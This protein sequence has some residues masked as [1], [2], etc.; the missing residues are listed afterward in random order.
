VAVDFRRE[1]GWGGW[2]RRAS[3]VVVLTDWYEI[4]IRKREKERWSAGE[5]DGGG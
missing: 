4:Y 3:E 5:Y 2:V 1:E